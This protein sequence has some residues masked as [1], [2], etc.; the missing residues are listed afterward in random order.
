MHFYKK[1]PAYFLII[2]IACMLLIFIPGADSGLKTTDGIYGKSTNYLKYISIDYPQFSLR[3][4]E[5]KALDQ[6]SPETAVTYSFQIAYGSKSQQIDWHKTD[7]RKDSFETFTVAN[8][9]YYIDLKRSDFMDRALP[10]GELIV[11]TS[12][13]HEQF[14]RSKRKIKRNNIH[15][16]NRSEIEHDQLH[17]KQEISKSLFETYRGYLQAL[18]MEED[19]DDVTSYLSDNNPLAQAKQV[20]QLYSR[21]NLELDVLQLHDAIISPLNA[22]LYLLASSAN[23]N[24]LIGVEFIKQQGKWKIADEKILPDNSDGKE[25]IKHFMLTKQNA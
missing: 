15:N 22:K 18:N 5:K 1:Y 19:D 6:S 21:H 17:A 14:E 3:F 24:M 23:K 10:D 13:Q 11:W 2:P 7:Y 25:W 20:K 4:I 8:Q 12:L 16:L 9:K